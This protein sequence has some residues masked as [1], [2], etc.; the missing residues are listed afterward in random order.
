LSFTSIDDETQAQRI[1]D[2]PV[3]LER[4]AVGARSLPPEPEMLPEKN[5]SG[6]ALIRLGLGLGAAALSWIVT[7]AITDNDVPRVALTLAF[8]TAGVVGYFD[9]KPGKPLPENIAANEL[10]TAEWRAEVARIEATNQQRRPGDRIVL[11]TGRPSVR[12]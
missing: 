11:E 5:P 6:P 10:A 1:L 4:S 8:T 12:R 7:P 2:V 3:R 9:K